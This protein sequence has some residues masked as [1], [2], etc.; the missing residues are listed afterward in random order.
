MR[1]FPHTVSQLGFVVPDLDAALA[2]WV[3]E[4]NVGPF[5]R[6]PSVD[7][8]DFVHRGQAG[9]A[10]IAA[11]LGNSGPMQIELIQPL[12][13]APSQWREFLDSGRVGLQHVGYWTDRFDDDLAAARAA[14][15]AEAHRGVISG[16]RF[17]Y[18]DT[19]DP[20]G[21]AIELSEQSP[22]K[23]EVFSA[24][25]AAAQDWD[26]TDPVRDFAKLVDQVPS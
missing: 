20:N 14:G 25:R 7:I 9:P 26:G 5:F 18:F 17:V 16:G 22:A 4:L 19:T 12:D 8:S 13:D 24:I 23:H 10:P 3:E 11:A 1:P 15:Y 2:H 21:C 6:T